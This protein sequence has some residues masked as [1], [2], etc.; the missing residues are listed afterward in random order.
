MPDLFARPLWWG[1]P[2]AP[3]EERSWHVLERLWLFVGHFRQGLLQD[4]CEP[5][6]SQGW[7][8]LLERTEPCWAILLHLRCCGVLEPWLDAKLRC[9]VRGVLLGLKAAVGCSTWGRATWV[10]DA[11][12]PRFVGPLSHT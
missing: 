9:L 12:L 8:S 5:R 10:P 1:P 3:G 7:R 4:L 2:L 11:Q 6:S